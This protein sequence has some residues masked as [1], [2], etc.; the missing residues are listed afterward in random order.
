MKK[1][2]IFFILLLMV[3][4]VSLY[5]VEFESVT[6]KY[7]SSC[8]D[9]DDGI[10]YE[11]GG[12]L[13]G[14]DGSTKRDFCFDDNTLHEY[15][16]LGS[17]SNGLVEVAKCDHGCV[18]EG[19][20]GRCLKKGERTLGNI[21]YN[22]CNDG[23]YFEGVC[24]NVGIRTNSGFFCDVD[25]D[26]GVQLLTGDACNNNFECK[27]NLCIASQCISEEVFSKFL[28]SLSG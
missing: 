26:F 16:C 12:N 21:K 11:T 25:E 17:S 1:V 8:T 28:I 2:D 20:K 3:G 7:V 9:S 10:E 24:I 18:E 14:F 15:Y 4:V 22:Q 13:V 5:K 23:C 6:G 19:G 27:S